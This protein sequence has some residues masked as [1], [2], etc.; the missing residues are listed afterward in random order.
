M[1]K[2]LFIAAMIMAASQYC[3][4]A[5][6]ELPVME[7]KADRTVIYPQRIQLAGEESLLDI[8]MMFPDIMQ[9]G[10]ESM[11]ESY[12]L[13]LDNVPLNGN[14][15][16]LCTQIKADLIEKIQICDNTGVAK[17][18]EGM[19]RVIDITMKRFESGA[20]GFVSAQAASK[21]FYSPSVELRVGSKSTDVYANAS[22]ANQSE[23]TITNTPSL[24]L[25][26]TNWLSERDRL[27]TYV[28]HQTTH[29][30]KSD[31]QE[32]WD[33]EHHDANLTMARARYFHNFNDKGTELLLVAGYQNRGNEEN[34][35]RYAVPPF[36]NE[37]LSGETTTKS[38]LGIAEICS[39]ITDKLSLMGGWEGNWNYYNLNSSLKDIIDHN[40]DGKPSASNQDIYLQLNY[41]LN[42][43]QFTA[44]ER[45]SFYHYNTQGKSKND[46]RHNIEASIINN[47]N[48]TSQIQAA[49]HRKFENPNFLLINQWVEPWHYLSENVIDEYKLA[50]KYS[51]PT[52]TLAAASTY[53]EIRQDENAYLNYS[54][55]KYMWRTN[56]S[57]YFRKGIFSMNMGINYYLPGDSNKNRDYATINIMPRLSTKDGWQMT[58]QAVV[59]TKEIAPSMY[60]NHNV[61]GSLDVHKQIGKHI[62]LC[63]QWHDIFHSKYSACLGGLKYCF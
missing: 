1:K 43:W 19:N 40:F 4:M 44:G 25:H 49:Y 58:V 52:F 41:K 31:Y 8:L 47:I 59:F 45:V 18:T 24:S 15:R 62:D 30:E 26:M 6:Q 28:T 2:H 35:I 53:Y 37:Q 27:L 14:A 32:Y 36:S 9:T 57:S 20:H 21:H 13:R 22:L 10:F 60:D 3:T 61:Y 23:S 46:T 55:D 54:K 17:G 42:K 48:N 50:Y 5:A 51:K 7:M 63:A 56:I 12:N 39:P 16:L 38:L 33:R 29:Y 34:Y 11:I